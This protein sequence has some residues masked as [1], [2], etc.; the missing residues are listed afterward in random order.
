MVVSSVCT[1]T[2]YL[3]QYLEKIDDWDIWILICQHAY[4]STQH[5]ATGFSPHELVLGERVRTPSS[6]P[7]REKVAD[8]GD[9]LT[10]LIEQRAQSQTLAAMNLV[11]SKYH[12][13]FY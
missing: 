5:D 2:E 3:K 8:Y 9:Y 1:L 12:S 6:F 4:N 11:Q 7:P 13:K 10:K